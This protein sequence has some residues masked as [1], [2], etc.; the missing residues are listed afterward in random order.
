MPGVKEHA[1]HAITQLHSFTEDFVR[2]KSRLSVVRT[3]ISAKQTF[4]TNNIVWHDAPVSNREVTDFLSDAS[5]VAG[6]AASQRSRVST[7]SG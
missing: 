1:E 6:S 3:E 2:Y 7:A 5:S 4:T